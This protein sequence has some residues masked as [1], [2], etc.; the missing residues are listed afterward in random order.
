MEKH[1]RLAMRKSRKKAL[2][3]IARKITVIIWHIPVHKQGYNPHLLPVYDKAKMEAKINYHQ[4]EIE[5]LE[6]LTGRQPVLQ[7]K[8]EKAGYL[9]DGEKPCLQIGQ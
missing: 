8:C 7:N 4:K 6:K 1:N 5:R 2:V 3:A 9:C